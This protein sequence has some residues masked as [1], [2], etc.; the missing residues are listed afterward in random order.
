MRVVFRFHVSTKMDKGN[1][2]SYQHDI[3]KD[4]ETNTSVGINIDDIDFPSIFSVKD[5]VSI[6][7][8]K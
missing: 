3:L 7:L 2:N 8:R 5:V 6:V 1:T 4:R